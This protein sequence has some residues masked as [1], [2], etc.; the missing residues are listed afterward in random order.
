MYSL[1]ILDINLL[2]EGS[3]ASGICLIV[4]GRVGVIIIKMKGTVNVMLLNHP[5]TIFPLPCP[6]PGKI[7]FHKTSPWC[8]KDWRSL[9]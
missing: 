8:Q 1:F 5:E 4:W 9:F 6:V 7:V 3:P 2:T